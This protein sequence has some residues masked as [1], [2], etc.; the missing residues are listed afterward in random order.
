VKRLIYLL[1]VLLCPIGSPAFAQWGPTPS[2]SSWARPSQPSQPTRDNNGNPVQYDEQGRPIERRLDNNG[3]PITTAQPKVVSQQQNTSDCRVFLPAPFDIKEYFYKGVCLDGLG[4]GYQKTKAFTPKGGQL[5]S[6]ETTFVRGYPTGKIAIGNDID[7]ALAGDILADG[8]ISGMSSGRGGVLQAGIFRNGVFTDGLVQKLNQ[9]TEFVVDGRATSEAEYRAKQSV[10]ASTPAENRTVNGEPPCYLEQPFIKQGNTLTGQYAGRCINE[11][12]NGKAVLSLL[13]QSNKWGDPLIFTV[14][15]KDGKPFGT[16]MIDSGNGA[17]IFT[18]TLKNWQPWNGYTE[19]FDQN[20]RPV[21]F[22]TRNGQD[23][24]YTQIGQIPVFTAYD[25]PAPLASTLKPKKGACDADRPT[26]RYFVTGEYPGECRA[27]RYTGTAELTLT[28]KDASQPTIKIKAP[29]QN[30]Y[31]SGP[32]V[33]KYPQYGITYKGTFDGWTPQD[34]ISEQP[35]GDRNFLVK[36]YRAGVE[37][38]SRSEY[39]PP[40]ELELALIDAAGRFGERLGTQLGQEIDGTA[41]RQRQQKRE[42][43]AYQARQQDIARANDITRQAQATAGQQVRDEQI[44][45]QQANDQA[46]AE[47]QRQSD[48]TIEDARRKAL[49]GLDRDGNPLPQPVPRVEVARND[50]PP[51]FGGTTN[52][53][54]FGG[55]ARP[56]GD[57]PVVTTMPPDLPAPHPAAPTLPDPVRWVEPLALPVPAPVQVASLPDPITPQP[58]GVPPPLGPATR[59]TEPSDAPQPLAPPVQLGNGSDTLGIGSAPSN[60]VPQQPS[61]PAVDV[62]S[63]PNATPA[64]TSSSSPAQQARPNAPAETYP[65]YPTEQ[66]AIAFADSTPTFG[67]SGISDAT[68]YQVAARN[69]GTGMLEINETVRSTSFTPLRPLAA[70]QLFRWNVMACNGSGCSA[71]SGSKYFRTAGATTSPQTGESLA[72]NAWAAASQGTKDC[73]ITLARET[74]ESLENAFQLVTSAGGWQQLAGGVANSAWNIIRHPILSAKAV[75]N[76]LTG[77][78]SGVRDAVSAGNPS[79]ACQRAVKLS[80]SVIGA[81]E[82]AQAARATFNNLR[83]VANDNGQI[84]N[85]ATRATGGSSRGVWDDAYGA[86]RGD[87][88]HQRLGQNTPANYPAVDIWNLSTGRAVSIKSMDTTAA[89]YQSANAFRATLNGY[90]DQIANFSG[91]DN[92]GL[93]ILSEQIRSRELLLAVPPEGLTPTQLDALVIVRERA[94]LKGVSIIITTI[95]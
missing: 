39:R 14:N 3:N 22:G 91:A 62:A 32:V 76:G 78:I 80:A 42:A 68:Y 24:P 28:P 7:Y 4:T 72:S 17:M 36:E 59:V 5:V 6:I 29:F 53:P 63:R 26:D 57:P 61:Q 1:S 2:E 86:S 88:I 93:E 38:S 46:Q 44:A 49:A 81:A 90:V 40:S 27:G 34:G 37:V 9:P 95:S 54:E 75:W 45:Q 85:A 18:G 69:L 16:A 10:A 33:A 43:D 84:A 19:A 66:S 74:G 21:R 12:Y 89:T 51:L 94:R 48:A 35:T 67:W 13:D 50:P 87:I 25:P 56:Q 47:W 8:S 70:G 52:R 73:A 15:Y 92:S 79:L 20:N 71:P 41:G 82:G 31:L 11:R 23:A 55:D 64:S 65:G 77:Q 58:N 60:P 30:G 83:R